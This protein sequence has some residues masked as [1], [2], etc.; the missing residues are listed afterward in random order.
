M[1]QERWEQI[2]ALLC[3]F[4]RVLRVMLIMLTIFFLL[5]LVSFFSVDRDSGTYL[6]VL[7]NLVMFGGGLIVIGVIL[8]KCSTRGIQ[9]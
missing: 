6:I 5:T 8:R 4:E 2:W 9:R 1:N 7:Y 3:G